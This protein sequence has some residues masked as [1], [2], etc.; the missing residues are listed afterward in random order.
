MWSRSRW[1]R[2]CPRPVSRSLRRSS[3]GQAEV[4]PSPDRRSEFVNEPVA[5]FSRPQVRAAMAGAVE[6]VRRKSGLR[7]DISTLACHAP[8]GPDLRSFNPSRP[9]QLVAVVQSYQPA[10]VAGLMKAAE[11]HTEEWKDRTVADRVAVMRKAASLM[12]VQRWELAAWEVF[13]EG[14]PWREADAD[15]AE[16]IDFLEYYAGECTTGAPQ[17]TGPLSGRGE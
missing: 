1:R 16:A 9:D 6:D 5:D 13:E 15:V 7:L 14:K 17:P 8:T 3:S 10:D 12:R 2:C 11:A 4:S